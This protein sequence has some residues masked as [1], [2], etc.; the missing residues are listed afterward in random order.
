MYKNAHAIA[1]QKAALRK[2]PL[3]KASSVATPKNRRNIVKFIPNLIFLIFAS[4]Q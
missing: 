4:F 2:L 1:N 3:W